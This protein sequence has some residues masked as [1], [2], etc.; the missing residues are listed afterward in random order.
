MKR[1]RCG[2]ARLLYKTYVSYNFYQ[3]KKINAKK[4]RV[5]PRFTVQADD[6]L[7]N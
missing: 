6:D 1:K 7:S 2:N 4:P 3:T 5:Y